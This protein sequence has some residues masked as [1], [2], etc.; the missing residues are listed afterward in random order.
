MHL[1]KIRTILALKV[2]VIVFSY[3]WCFF[4]T[5]HNKTCIQFERLNDWQKNNRN[6][7]VSMCYVQ[8]AGHFWPLKVHQNFSYLNF[9]KVLKYFYFSKQPLHLI[10]KKKLKKCFHYFIRCVVCASQGTTQNRSRTKNVFKNQKK[11][12]FIFLSVKTDG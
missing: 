2:V 4:Y 3:N 8:L 11:L 1:G 12:E 7:W 10:M 9:S 6:D 5:K